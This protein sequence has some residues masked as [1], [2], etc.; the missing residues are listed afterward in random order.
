MTFSLPSDEGTLV[1]VPIAG[2]RAT[3]LDFFSPTCEPCKKKVPE[4]LAHRDELAKKNVKVVLVA[5]LAESEPTDAARKALASWGAPSPFLVDRGDASK[6]EAGVTTLP[7]TL[8]LDASGRV[9]FRS[10][11]TSSVGEALG[12]VP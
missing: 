10:T 1:K 9:V 11:A 8:V 5:V 4:L 3:V 6:V 7:T 2:A 12:A